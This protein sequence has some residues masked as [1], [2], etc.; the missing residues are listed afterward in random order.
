MVRT[1]VSLLRGRTEYGDSVED[2]W[3]VVWLL[4]EMSKKFQDLWIKVTDNDGEFLLVEASGTIPAWLEPEV[5][6]NRVWIHDGS[7]IIVKPAKAA[8]SSKRTDETLSLQDAREIILKDTKRLMHSPIIEEE[9]FY[10]IRDYPN[11]I[12]QNMHHTLMALP[13]KIAFLLHQKPAYVAPATE[14][15]YLRD[16]IALKPLQAAK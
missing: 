16:P 2:E 15:F 10:R 11:K 14:A 8:R 9:A 6:E 1:G 4:R 13:R 3:V 7:F 5:A 12:K